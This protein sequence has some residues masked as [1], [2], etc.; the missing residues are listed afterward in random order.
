M[1]NYN[2]IELDKSILEDQFLDKMA[3]GVINFII[4]SDLEF[5]HPGIYIKDIIEDKNISTEQFAENVGIS[6]DA[7]NKLVNSE[8]S[9]TDDIANKLNDFTGI[10]AK[11]WMNLQK[12][13]DKRSFEYKNLNNN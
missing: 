5:Y 4:E 13:F 2:I 3:D 7:I 8:V 1:S 9:I 10:S 11:T 6:V 12:N